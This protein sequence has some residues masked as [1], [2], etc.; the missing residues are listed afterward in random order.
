VSVGEDV[1]GGFSGNNVAFVRKGPSPSIGIQWRLE[2][3]GGGQSAVGCWRFS[4]TRVGVGG[5]VS[6]GKKGGISEWVSFS[7]VGLGG[8]L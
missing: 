1:L 6:G 2:L 8:T 5:W 4:L 3:S 7:C